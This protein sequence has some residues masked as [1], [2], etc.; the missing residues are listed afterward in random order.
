[1]MYLSLHLHLGARWISAKANRIQL[2]QFLKR[3]MQL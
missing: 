2:R 1:M 3:V